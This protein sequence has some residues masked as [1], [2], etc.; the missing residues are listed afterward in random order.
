MEIIILIIAGYAII[1][2]ARFTLNYLSKN[3]D[4]GITIDEPETEEEKKAAKK[5]CKSKALK[6]Y[7]DEAKLP[8]LV[9]KLPE[10]HEKN[11][12]TA[13]ILFFIYVAIIVVAACGLMSWF[14]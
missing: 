4:S 5:A 1:K 2:G 14:N 8:I 10:K 3:Y 7:G 13:L 6:L 11:K 9:Y 12:N